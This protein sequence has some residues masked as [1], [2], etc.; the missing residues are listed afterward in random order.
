[1]EKIDVDF[2]CSTDGQGLW[3]NATRDVKIT[4]LELRWFDC[5]SKKEV[6]EDPNLKARKVGELMVYFAPDSWNVRDFGLIYT[7]DLFESQLNEHVKSILG[8]AQPGLQEG[9]VVGSDYPDNDIS[10]SEAGMQGNTFVSFDVSSN[11]MENWFKYFIKQDP[12]KYLTH[13][14]EEIRDLAKKLL[15]QLK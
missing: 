8:I 14:D 4:S 15:S 13:E 1:M 10:Y 7:D 5:Y 2:I 9:I 3:S 11:F 6:Q 12:E